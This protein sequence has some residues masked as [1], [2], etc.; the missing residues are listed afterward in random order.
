MKGLWGLE[1][2]SLLTEDPESLYLSAQPACR[3]ASI[4]KIPRCS[5]ASQLSCLYVQTGR[6]KG[7]KTK[8]HLPTGQPVLQGLLQMHCCLS[9]S[10][11]SGSAS[12]Q[13]HVRAEISIMFFSTGKAPVETTPLL[14]AAQHPASF[15]CVIR[16]R[17]CFPLQGP[18]ASPSLPS[19]AAVKTRD[20]Q[21]MP[22]SSSC[23]S[24]T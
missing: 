22:S 8:R 13:P 18:G 24:A 12:H 9:F 2:A 14:L 6:R 1:R 23:R 19:P 17:A 7:E 20:H 15:F 3:M 21:L 16:I 4:S 10:P 5:Q 11:P